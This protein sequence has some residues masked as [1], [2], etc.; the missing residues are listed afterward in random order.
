MLIQSGCTGSLLSKNDK[1][2]HSAY[3]NGQECCSKFIQVSIVCP[4]QTNGLSLL[5]MH[6]CSHLTPLHYLG[7]S[8]F[9]PISVWSWWNLQHYQ[10]ITQSPDRLKLALFSILLILILLYIYF[11]IF[12]ESSFCCTSAHI[13]ALLCSQ[14][15]CCSNSADWKI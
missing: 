6:G 7:W 4:E 3:W 5:N 12:T 2:T 14:H 1:L 13:P 9:A 15:S 8:S 10:S 11:Y